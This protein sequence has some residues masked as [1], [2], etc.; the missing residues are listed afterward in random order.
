M[1]HGIVDNVLQKLRAALAAMHGT[2]EQAQRN[3]EVVQARHGDIVWYDGVT[4][5]HYEIWPPQTAKCR[6]ILF[7]NTTPK[8]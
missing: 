7:I 3:M 6:E 8:K 4:D 1:F 5:L 2:A